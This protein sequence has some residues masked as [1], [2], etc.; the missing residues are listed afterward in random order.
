M[1]S[2]PF[3][4]KDVTEAIAKAMNRR[5]QKLL[6][7]G[8][9]SNKAYSRVPRELENTLNRLMKDYVFPEEMGSEGRLDL[10]ED[11]E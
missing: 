6:S 4:E 7:K 5:Y 2:G 11:G 8:M 1:N 3:K 9:T 10:D